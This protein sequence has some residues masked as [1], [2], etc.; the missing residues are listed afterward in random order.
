VTDTFNS[1]WGASLR[2][3][4]WTVF[5]PILSGATLRD[6]LMACAGA[7]VG[8]GLTGLICGWAAGRGFDLP[9]LVAPMGASSVLVFAVPTSPLAQPWPVIGG[10]IIS[11]LIGVFVAHLVPQPVLAAGLA[12]GLAILA[13]SFTRSLHPPGGAAALVAAFGGAS[14]TASDF[15]FPLFPVGVNACLL[16]A[17]AWAFHKL[18][19]NSYPHRA[20]KTPPVA[21]HGTR[22][23]PAGQRVGFKP[24]DIDAAL[25]NL[26]EAFDISR[27]DL[28]VVLREVENQALIREHGTLT[29]ADI[30]S[31]D[32]VQ[33]EW[34][35]VPMAARA[36]LTAHDVRDLPVTDEEGRVVGV[37]G[38]KQLAA[39][40]IRVADVMVEAVF[41]A[42]QTPAIELMRLFTAGQTRTV[43]IADEEKQLLGVV[44]QTDLLAAISSG[45]LKDM[46]RDVAA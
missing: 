40:A 22:D 41:A 35:A 43:V 1:Q 42:P 23:L 38:F 15:W 39:P 19:R 32:V 21:D 16:V 29:C 30:M 12:A 7:A 31:R 5:R 28:D 8:I 3:R 18:A 25:E 20:T 9:L 11:A 33:I 24:E 34:K 45:L 46:H 36:R 6:R 37:V 4:S 14:V 26:G 10:N 27:A 17:S 13:M 44:T 2:A